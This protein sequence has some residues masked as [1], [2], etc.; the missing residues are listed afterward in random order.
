MSKY[1]SIVVLTGAGISAES[2]IRT[3]R[4]SDGL[5]ENHPVEEVATPEGYYRNP[6]LV[7]T[8]Y[9]QRRQQ[10]SEVDVNQAHLALADFEKTF[11]G[12]FLLV[13]QNVDD[14]HERAGSRHLIHLHGELYKV[15]CQDTEQVFEWKQDVTLETECPCCHKPG[16]LRPHIVWF[17][18]MPLEMERIYDALSRCD[19]FI[20]IGTSG[21]VYPAAGF[22]QEALAAGA[23][24]VELN[25][26]PSETRDAFLEAVHG[27]ATRVV[28]QYLSQLR[29][30][31][32]GSS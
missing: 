9:N 28:P 27:P 5:W 23:H 17:G 18:E 30:D 29:G 15:R 21:N 16:N 32:D 7:Q 19:L 1:K 12:E 26:E 10:L 6:A 14:L 25:L 24:T 31:D 3:F 22:C 20:S 4:A 2:G 8:F 11:D 13:T